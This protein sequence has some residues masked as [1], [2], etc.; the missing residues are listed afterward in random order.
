[1]NLNFISERRSSFSSDFSF[2]ISSL[3]SLSVLVAT[4]DFRYL[5]MTP[6]V[7][8][9]NI[10]VVIKNIKVV[11]TKGLDGCLF[12]YPNNEWKIFEEK[13][14]TLPLTNKNARTFTRFFLGSAVDGG[15][16]KQGRVLISSA[17]RTF[18]GLE[19]EVVL[20]GVLDRVEIWDKAKWDDNNAVV[21]E[22][23]DDIASQ[24]EELGLGI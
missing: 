15:L 3:L 13:L 22:D 16:D 21:E 11:I 2:S 19:K 10:T 6:V 4:V 7:R 18:A 24:M 8:R 14:R 20:V 12:L 9:P 5:I 1:M 17:L 23:M